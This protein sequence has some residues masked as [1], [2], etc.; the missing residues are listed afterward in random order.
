MGFLKDSLGFLGFLL[1][2]LGFLW[3]SWDSCGIP[4]IPRIP[5]GFLGFLRDSWDSRDSYW[6]SGIPIRIPKGMYEIPSSDL[7][8]D[9]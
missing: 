9:N 8:L 3:D 6:D 7:P 2:F 5:E 1:G 4:G